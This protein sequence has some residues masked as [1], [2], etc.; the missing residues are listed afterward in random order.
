MS[1]FVPPITLYV[2]TV[3]NDLF[4]IFPWTYMSYCV[5]P[6][7]DVVYT[8]K[9]CFYFPSFHGQSLTHMF[10]KFT[11]LDTRVHT[12]QYW[13]RWYARYIYIG[14]NKHEIIHNTKFSVM[15]FIEQCKPYYGGKAALLFSIKSKI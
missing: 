14:Q 10:S 13:S 4:S 1:D 6:Y 11:T 12:Q 5:P 7:Y 3:K 15:I 9:N 8:V 2:Y